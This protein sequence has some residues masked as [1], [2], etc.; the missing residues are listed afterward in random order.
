M[1]NTI[2]PKKSPFS[3]KSK[4]Q[5]KVSHEDIE[6]ATKEFIKSGGKIKTLPPGDIFTLV[7]LESLYESKDTVKRETSRYKNQRSSG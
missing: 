7:D 2:S 6:L 1:S 3:F 4:K 5:K